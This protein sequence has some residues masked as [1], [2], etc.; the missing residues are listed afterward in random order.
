MAAAALGQPESVAALARAGALVNAVDARGC[1]ALWHATWRGAD[2]AAVET[3]HELLRLGADPRVGRALELPHGPYLQDLQA[4]LA[5]AEAGSFYAGA[6]TIL[7]L[8]AGSGGGGSGG[9]GSGSVS[10]NGGGGGG[11]VSGGGGG[12]GSSVAADALQDGWTTAASAGKSPAS[13]GSAPLLSSPQSASAAGSASAAHTLAQALAAAPA[14]GA[15]DVLSAVRSLQNRHA[16]LYMRLAE[17]ERCVARAQSH[18]RVADAAVGS[19]DV[20]GGGSPAHAAVHAQAHASKELSAACARLET[21][22]ADADAVVRDTENMSRALPEAAGGGGGGGGGGL[23]AGAR[24]LLEGNGGANTVV[25]ATLTTA[26]AAAIAWQIAG[27]RRA[28]VGNVGGMGGALGGGGNGGGGGGGAGVVRGNL[29]R[30]L[31]M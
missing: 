26:A 19:G 16:A 23:L 18:V 6:S 21:F 20:G 25:L 22:H 11:G 31:R 30:M 10:S 1:T 14:R 5:A 29:V 24:A 9:G 2:K 3:V 8:D 17:L 28:A 7:A 13:Q 15:E 4:M 12:G 27:G